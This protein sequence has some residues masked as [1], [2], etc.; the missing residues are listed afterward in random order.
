MAIEQWAGLGRRHPLTGAAFA[1]LMLAFAGIPLTSGF[2][3]KIAAFMPAIAHGGL[4]GVLL[5]VIGA[6]ASVVTAYMYIRVIVIM[7]FEEPEG[8]VVVAAPAS[9]TM[10]AII[11]GVLLTFVLGVFPAPLLDLA[12]MSSVLIAG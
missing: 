6:L 11:V 3:A 8:D 7:F 10:V 4:A 2:T 5:V 1:F 12:Q 9:M